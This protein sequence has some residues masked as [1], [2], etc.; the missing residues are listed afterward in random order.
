MENGTTNHTNGK[1]HSTSLVPVRPS[2]LGH[3]ATTKY[4]KVLDL[5]KEVVHLE[6]EHKEKLEELEKEMREVG[7]SELP[8]VLMSFVRRNSEPPA[9][10]PP[11]KAKPRKA[12]IMGGALK[13]RILGLM[14]DKQERKSKRIVQELKIKNATSVYSILSD[15]V[16]EGHLIRTRYAHY[17]LK[18]RNV[19]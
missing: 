8:T 1:S 19:K 10:L 11:V 18:L 15:L 4:D 12:S 5:V 3:S 2:L 9:P 13:A 6:L 7:V 14:S 16:D 17:R